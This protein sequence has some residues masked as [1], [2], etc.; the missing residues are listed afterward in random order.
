MTRSDRLSVDWSVS[1][2][3]VVGRLVCHNIK[4]SLPML[5]SELLIA[6]K[7]VLLSLF[8]SISLSLSPLFLFLNLSLSLPP[9]FLSF[10][11][12]LNFYLSNNRARLN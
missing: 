9:L 12:F 3:V 6:Y 10:S 8:L 7:I 11:H 4:F 2:A 5:L 1:R